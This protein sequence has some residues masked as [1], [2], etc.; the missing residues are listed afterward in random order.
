MRNNT[1]GFAPDAEVS[2]NYVKKL[3]GGDYEKTNA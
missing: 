2:V 1:V 3:N